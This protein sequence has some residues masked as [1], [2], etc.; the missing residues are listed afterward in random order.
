M[1]VFR[2][3]A[4]LLIPPSSRGSDLEFRSLTDPRTVTELLN[5]QEMLEKVIRQADLEMS[6]IELRGQLQVS[7]QGHLSDKVDIV[8]MVLIGPDAEKLGRLGSGLVVCF[9]QGLKD[10]A[11]VEH[12]Q[13][14]KFLEKEYRRGQ[15]RLRQAYA[16]ARRSGIREDR[17]VPQRLAQLRTRQLEL[18]RQIQTLD[19]NDPVAEPSGPL[20][21]E[22]SQQ[23]L[24]MA[25]LRNVY[26]D[27]STQVQFQNRR[28]QRLHALVERQSLQRAQRWR[29]MHQ[30]QSARLLSGLRRVEREL[31]EVQ[32]GQPS[33]RQILEN[34]T[35]QR[36]LQMWQANVDA[37]RQQIQRA[38]FAR[39]QT[40]ARVSVVV[41]EKPGRGEAIP[42]PC[43]EL[44]GLWMWWSRL[45]ESLF[46][47]LVLTFLLH[48][49]KSQLAMEQRIVE[50][51]GLP[52]LGRIPSLPRDLARQWERMKSSPGVSRQGGQEA[53]GGI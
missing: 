3:S 43:L 42:L 15:A 34:S 27:R 13:S 11:V 23:Q 18:Q 14:L 35:R 40:A 10:L 33:L 41:V 9:I 7:T 20:A 36:E 53:G 8:E 32:R 44:E 28:L 16:L 31:A 22:C 17:S 24:A 47:G 50:S 52:V 25:R 21:D 49:L 38:R 37:L 39:E 26:L 46:L 1:P 5:S 19:L 45:P 30:A 29:R 4:K 51:L 48:F 2:T 12:D 6:W